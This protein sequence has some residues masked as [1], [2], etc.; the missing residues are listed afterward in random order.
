MGPEFQP[1]RLVSLGELSSPQRH[2]LAHD[3]ARFE[4]HDGSG[5]DRNVRFGLVGVAADSWFGQPDLEYP[6]IA[7]FTI[8]PNAN[9]TDRPISA[10]ITAPF[11]FEAIEAS[12]F[13]SPRLHRH[14]D[15][16]WCQPHIHV[17][18]MITDD[19]WASFLALARFR[20]S[21][22]AE[23]FIAHSELVQTCGF[24]SPF[25]ADLEG[26]WRVNPQDDFD[27]K[28]QHESGH[29]PEPSMI[30]FWRK[31]DESPK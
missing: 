8:L 24:E 17:S 20:L 22:N 2:P 28:G 29:P 19:Q 10:A 5:R 15:S 3:L 23:F 27:Y 9:R 13:P 7:E 6:E 16:Y 30:R 4:L 12:C 25:W 21:D 18:I 11:E 31:A 1:Q 14:F 26:R